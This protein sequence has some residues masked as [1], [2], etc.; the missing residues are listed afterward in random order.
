MVSKDDQLFF[1]LRDD[2]VEEERYFSW[3]FVSRSP[4]RPFLIAEN[5]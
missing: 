5:Y 2:A 3:S 4:F 1:L